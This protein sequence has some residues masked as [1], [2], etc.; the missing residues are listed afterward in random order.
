MTMGRNDADT[1]RFVEAENVLLFRRRLR[2]TID[3]A[4][5]L[6][7]LRL[8]GEQAAKGRSSPEEEQVASVKVD[9]P[10]SR[11]AS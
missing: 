5:R 7:L 3:P 1:D 8:L 6:R 4:Q 11:G 9:D 2:E 10:G